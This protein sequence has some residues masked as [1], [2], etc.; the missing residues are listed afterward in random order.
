V[1]QVDQ[2]DEPEDLWDFFSTEDTP[3]VCEAKSTVASEFNA[4]VML[5]HTTRRRAPKELKNTE[6]KVAALEKFISLVRCAF[7]QS[8]SHQT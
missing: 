1:V 6:G 8:T 3:G 2:G 4:P 5:N 7:I